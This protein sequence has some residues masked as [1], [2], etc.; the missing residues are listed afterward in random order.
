M[1]FVTTQ[2]VNYVSRSYV[3]TSTLKLFLN[4]DEWRLTLLLS[5]CIH[6]VSKRASNWYC[7]FVDIKGIAQLYRYVASPPAVIANVRSAN[8]SNDLIFVYKTDKKLFAIQW[9]INGS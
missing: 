8:L 6:T 3:I 4:P 9:Q 2:I 1:Y 5:G 7:Q